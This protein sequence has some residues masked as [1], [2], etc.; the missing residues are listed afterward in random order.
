MGQV[1]V[2]RV[3]HP[4]HNEIVIVAYDSAIPFHR[5]RL[6]VERRVREQKVEEAEITEH[7]P[8]VVKRPPLGLVGGTVYADDVVFIVPLLA[9]LHGVVPDEGSVGGRCEEEGA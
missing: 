8:K 4:V 6:A 5:R 9:F 1:Y 2:G 3:H 7:I